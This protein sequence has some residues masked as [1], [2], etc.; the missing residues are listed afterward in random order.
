MGRTST[1]VGCTPHPKHSSG[2]TRKKE[3]SLSV[4]CRLVTRFDFITV[5]EVF[6]KRAP[7]T[8]H[9][10][11]APARALRAGRISGPPASGNPR[12]ARAT[13]RRFC[14]VGLTGEETHEHIPTGKSRFRA[15]RALTPH[16]SSSLS[17]P[18]IQEVF[19]VPPTIFWKPTVE[20]LTLS[21]LIIIERVQN[22]LKVL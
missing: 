22:F 13:R 20:A 10:T 21:W 3:T 15:S 18:R 19:Q 4:G 8:E 5:Q 7:G 11:V 9:R 16:A 6:A 12:E 2:T 1:A 17:I 14:S